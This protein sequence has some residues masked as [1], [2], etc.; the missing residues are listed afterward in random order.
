MEVLGRA[1]GQTEA[2]RAMGCS[3]FKTFI[4]IV[5][6]QAARMSLPVFKNECV[7]LLKGTSIVGYISIIDITKASDLIRSA[8]FEAFI[9]LILI[10]VF[11]FIMASIIT[12][13]LDHV[14]NKL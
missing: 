4:Y 8:T 9:P 1:F 6:P 13:A 7:T 11:Y 5:A 2:G 12:T 10:T 3:A 14:M